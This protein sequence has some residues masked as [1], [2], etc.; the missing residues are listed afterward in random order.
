MATNTL[1]SEKGTS[2]TLS[3]TNLCDRLKLQYVSLKS[4]SRLFE[5]QSQ[6]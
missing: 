3:S 4:I 1:V 2:H 5:E 6:I